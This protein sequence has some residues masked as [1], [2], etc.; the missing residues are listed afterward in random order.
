MTEPTLVVAMAAAL[1]SV[2]AGMELKL[3]PVMP[4]TVVASVPPQALRSA[5]PAIADERGSIGPAESI[6]RTFRR[7]V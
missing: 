1:A 2:G 3:T 6:F 5:L 7:E 4:A